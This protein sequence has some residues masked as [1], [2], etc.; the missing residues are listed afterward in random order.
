M[1]RHYR[2]YRGI[3]IEQQRTP[4]GLDSDNY[5]SHYFFKVNGKL[6][7]AGLL[8]DAKAKIDRLITQKGEG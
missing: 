6:N 4:M 8:R 5:Y 1:S 7:T 2:K 3:E